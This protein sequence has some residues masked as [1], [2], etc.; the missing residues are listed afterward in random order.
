MSA[1]EGGSVRVAAAL[2]DAHGARQFQ[3]GFQQQ[4]VGAVLQK[5]EGDRHGVAILGGALVKTP[6]VSSCWRASGVNASHIKSLVMSAAGAISTMPAMRRAARGI[7]AQ[8]DLG[9][10]KRQPATHAGAHD[11]AFGRLLDEHVNGSI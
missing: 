10:Q 3:P 6:R 4:S 2:Q 9:Q 5:L 7:I 11:D 1:C 8:Q